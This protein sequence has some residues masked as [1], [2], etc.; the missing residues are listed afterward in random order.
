MIYCLNDF[1]QWPMSAPVL[2][3]DAPHETGKF[4]DANLYM[5]QL[6]DTDDHGHSWIKT[7]FPDPMVMPDH[8]SFRNLLHFDGQRDDWQIAR[9]DVA[10]YHDQPIG[11]LISCGRDL[12]C[13]YIN[14]FISDTA[15][16]MRAVADLRR[17]AGKLSIRLDWRESIV[18]PDQPLPPLSRFF[19]Y[20]IADRQITRTLP[21]DGDLP[22]AYL[23][24][25][26]TMVEH[27]HTF[28]F[29]QLRPP[30]A[31][32]ALGARELG[33][34]LYRA[35]MLQMLVDGIQQERF[36]FDRAAQIDFYD[37]RDW[38]PIIV[39]GP[40][41]VFVFVT[42]GELMLAETTDP[43]WRMKWRNA[44][45]LRQLSE[46]PGDFTVLLDQYRKKSL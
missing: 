8:L 23:T 43:S 4:L 16:F 35:S 20:Q 40:Q 46:D 11:L 19:G 39:A 7:F 21:R 17:A 41:G 24:T 15:L 12:Y 30:G 22:F 44:T 33:N 2:W 18:S 37:Q 6:A 31:N 36:P 28:W 42:P 13:D 3:R 1:Y 45:T 34:P 29:D 14:R 32:A 26:N 10:F 27:L 5:D 25:V 9:L 38:L